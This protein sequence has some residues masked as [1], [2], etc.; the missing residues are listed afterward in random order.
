MYFL[1][2][3]IRASEDSTR[4]WYEIESIR[5]VMFVIIL[6]LIVLLL[7]TLLALV[8]KYNAEQHKCNKLI[9]GKTKDC[10]EKQRC[11]SEKEFNPKL[12]PPY[13]KEVKGTR[14][15]DGNMVYTYNDNYGVERK[16]IDEV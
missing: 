1:T 6:C 15:E 14:M 13:V 4:E 2:A 8:K 3:C 5:L 12:V 10:C 16:D 7:V 9:I 11:F